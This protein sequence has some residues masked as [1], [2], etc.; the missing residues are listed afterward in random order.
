LVGIHNISSFA[1]IDYRHSVRV[2]LG[3]A[4]EVR[5][6]RRTLTLFIWVRRKGRNVKQKEDG[7]VFSLHYEIS[8]FFPL[9]PP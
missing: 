2:P 8:F 7:R 4:L 5:R 6:E 1:F 9:L 3:R